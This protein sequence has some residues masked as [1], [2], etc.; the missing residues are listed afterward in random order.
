[1][2]IALDSGSNRIQGSGFIR[3]ITPCVSIFE[4]PESSRNAVS[5]MG[6]LIPVE[7]RTLGGKDGEQEAS[8]SSS[9]SSIGRNSDFSGEQG[10]DRE[11]GPEAQ[12]SYKGP[13]NALDS[14]EE[15]LPIRRGISSFYRGKSKS[16]TSLAD[17][18][19]AKD[20][21]KPD[22]PYNR[23]RK[24]LLAFSNIL[25]KNRNHLLRNSSDGSIS[26]RPT[27]SSRSTFSIA[28]AAS[29]CESN[30]SEGHEPPLPPLPPHGKSP[31]N[32]LMPQ[33]SFSSRSFSLTD[34]QEARATSSTSA[35]DKHTRF[36]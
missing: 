7:N 24:N 1:M 33:L 31:L 17:A 21:G 12:S 28:N 6:P 4:T 36:H 35:R 19:S 20:L 11:D 22:N 32:R 26:K 27:N 23:K 9:S 34:L 30:G 8:S 3:G 18:C 13:L 15:S 5:A 2:S 16:F 29:I 14:L 10:S 25:N